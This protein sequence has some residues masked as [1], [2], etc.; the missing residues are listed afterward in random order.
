MGVYK[1]ASAFANA[2]TIG[3]P[4]FSR[5]L[6]VRDEVIEVGKIYKSIV[7]SE[8][9]Q[10]FSEIRGKSLMNHAANTCGIESTLAIANLLCPEVVE[11]NDCIFISEFYNGNIDSL[12]E[13]YNGDKKKIEMFVNSWSLADLFLLASDESVHKDEIIEEFGKVIKH[14]WKLRLNELFPGKCIIVEVRDGI[15]G[16]RGLTVTVYQE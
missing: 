5:T 12:V 3:L 4:E 10:Y 1:K 7:N 16:E 8:I 9:M 14:F 11:I 2:L 15:M 6:K 13:Q